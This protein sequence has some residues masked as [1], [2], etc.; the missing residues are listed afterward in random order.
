MN[1]YVGQHDTTGF[2]VY[3]AEAPL[4]L[5]LHY[6]RSRDWRTEAGLRQV[7]L[8]ILIHHIGERVTP[9]MLRSKDTAV[10]AWLPH[11]HYASA[12]T[13][14]LWVNGDTYEVAPTSAQ[15]KSEPLTARG[16]HVRR[17]FGSW[18]LRPDQVQLW[19]DDWMWQ[20]HAAFLRKREPSSRCAYRYKEWEQFVREGL[21]TDDL[22]GH[23]LRLAWRF[24]WYLTGFSAHALTESWQHVH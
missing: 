19:L 7:A 12:L 6:T 9:Q 2:Q 14:I 15:R 24:R 3:T 17:R 16:N 10:A 1:D 11:L 5:H 4:P 18:T 8:D 13:S 22:D 20:T 23:G 21:G